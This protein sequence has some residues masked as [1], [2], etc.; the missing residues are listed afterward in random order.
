MYKLREIQHSQK[1]DGHNHVGIDGDDGVA[2]HLN[3]SANLQ[4]YNMNV[5]LY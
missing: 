3:F 2:P 4:S 5:I 1:Q